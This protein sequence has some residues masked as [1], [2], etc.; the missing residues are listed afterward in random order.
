[1][2]D[3]TFLKAWV[4]VKAFLRR[5]D[6]KILLVQDA[7]KT[8][9]HKHIKDKWDA[10]GGKMDEGEEDM[11][12]ALAREVQEE[13]GV[14]ITSTLDQARIVNAHVFKHYLGSYIC[15]HYYE[16]PVADDV[17]I[18]LSDEHTE[19]RWVTLDEAMHMELTI[20]TRQALED[21]AKL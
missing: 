14:D 2:E 9:I 1:M 12:I 21:Y 7:G 6:G 18:T 4:S 19:A 3:N 10:L 13:S 17:D 20:A 5:S 16:V 11:L 15:I 8:A